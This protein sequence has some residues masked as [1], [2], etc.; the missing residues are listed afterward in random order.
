MV[1]QIVFGLACSLR[2]SRKRLGLLGN[3]DRLL[4]ASDNGQSPNDRTFHVCEFNIK[5][6]DEF[7]RPRKAV[8]APQITSNSHQ[9]P[10]KMDKRVL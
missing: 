9:R 4:L 5:R 7:E 6:K 8:E 3:L 10:C 2:G 1:L